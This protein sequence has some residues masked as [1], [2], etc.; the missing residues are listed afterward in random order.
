MKVPTVAA[1][2]R[3][4]LANIVEVCTASQFERM[5]LYAKRRSYFLY[6]QNQ[7]AIVRFN[8]LKSHIALVS[9]FLYSEDG[10]AYSI[11]APS[12]ASE[13]QV[14]QFLAVEDEW[15]DEFRDSG[16]ATNCA[17]AILWSLVLD[18]MILKQGWN[19]RGGLFGELVEP[20]SIGFFREDRPFESQ[21]AINHSYLI[22]YDEACARLK[23]AGKAE[24]IASLAIVGEEASNSLPPVVSQL[25]ISATGGAN[26]SGNIM[27]EINPEYE[28]SPLYRPRM[29]TPLVRFNE[30]WVFDSDAGDMN[31]KERRGDWRIFESVSPGAI[32]S[33]SGETIGAIIKA[34]TEKS[35]KLAP[36]Y[37]STTNF[38]LKGEHPFTLFQPF[39]LYN[40]AWGEAHIEDLI[41]LQNWSNE[42]LDQINEILDRQ[43]DPAKSFTGFMSQDDT[44][45]AAWGAPGSWVSDQVPGA[46]AEAHP[47]EMPGDLFAE[48]SEIGNLMLEQS[49][50]TE[51]I[52]GRG[53][54]NVRGAGHH[55]ELKVTGGGRIRRIAV[56]LEKPLARVGDI[57]LRLKAK[58]D[59]DPIRMESGDEFVLAQLMT[60]SKHTLRV[61]GHSHSPLFT[62]ETRELSAMLL[63]AGSID[64]EWFIRLT[65]P[66]QRDNLVHALRNRIKAEAEAKKQM[67][68][69][70]I[71]PS[72]GRKSHLR[73]AQ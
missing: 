38:Y 69:A 8:R 65:N 20:S 6:G 17:D 15:N 30:T 59:D 27:G 47:P 52:V 41:P 60:G 67:M 63:K 73:A 16:L 40:Y 11:A 35:E 34:A 7:P 25:I 54:K 50:L 51:G 44:K 13:E 37:D 19:D 42:R 33:D 68:S 29:D 43:A 31:E 18:S 22:D 72:G 61:A 45:M 24:E 57:G 3:E 71:D 4:W 1:E 48:F 53:E 26:L 28:G 9:S 64:R 49:G 36:K 62:S 46:K 10:L 58:N 70:G 66:P 5:G 56:G 32:I 21:E 23:R 55:K 14:Q 39:N 2:K 12:N